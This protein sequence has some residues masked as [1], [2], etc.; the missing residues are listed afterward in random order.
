MVQTVD[1]SGSLQQDVAVELTAMTSRVRKNQ[2]SPPIRQKILNSYKPKS[3]FH[4]F[5]FFSVGWIACFSQPTIKAMALNCWIG[6][7]QPQPRGALP[8]SLR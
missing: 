1:L 6:Y 5:Q 7:Y 8:F 4:F 2:L 3:I